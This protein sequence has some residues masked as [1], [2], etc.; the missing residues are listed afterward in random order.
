MIA[1][2]ENFLV[3]LRPLRYTTLALSLLAALA[4]AL[5]SGLGVFVATNGI[6]YDR[7][8]GI[9]LGW[10]R[11]DAKVLMVAGAVDDAARGDETWLALLRQ[12][13]AQGARQ[14]VF[15]FVPRRASELFFE[16]ARRYGNVF[17]GRGLVAD[18]ASR[19][20]VGVEPLPA[21]AA[22]LPSG[23]VTLPPSEHGVYRDGRWT[24]RVG[25]RAVATLVGAVAGGGAELGTEDGFRIDFSGGEAGLPRL[26]LKQA[27]EGGLIPELV[28]G[29]TVL[30]GVDGPELRTLFTPLAERGVLLSPLQ[31]QAH[32]LDTALGG[33]EIAMPGLP[34]VVLLVL[35][36]TFVSLIGFQWL[37]VRVSGAVTLALL[38]VYGAVAWLALHTFHFWAPLSEAWL[39]QGVAYAA[40]VRH[41]HDAVM[42]VLRKIA[43]ESAARLRQR[44][45]P[46]TFFG[47]KAH[48]SQV[49]N[50]VNQTLS[51]ERSIFLERVESDHRVRE[52]VALNCGI[53]DIAEKRRDYERTPYSTAIAENRMLAVKDYMRGG[54]DGETQYLVPLLFAGDVRGFWV[55]GVR[56]EHLHI[57]TESE[58]MI[59]NMSAQI[60]EM[61]YHRQQWQRE[62]ELDANPVARYL[63]LEGGE[64]IAGEAR[65]AVSALEKRMSTLED[66]L[67]GSSSATILYDLFGQVFFANQRMALLLR[68]ANLAPYDMTAADLISS[69]GNFSL[70][71]ARKILRGVILDRRGVTLPASIGSLP[72]QSI[73]L[74]VM[75]LSPRQSGADA[76]AGKTLPF[77]LMGILCELVDVTSIRQ[78][79]QL[80]ETL[81]ERVGFQLRNDLESVVAAAS[82]LSEEGLDP[83]SRKRVLEILRLKTEGMGA[84]LDESQTLLDRGLEDGSLLEC[85][86]VDGKTPL[87]SA[88][89]SLEAEFAA[90]RVSVEIHLP[91]LTSL[92]FAAS[93]ELRQMLRGILQV[94]LRDTSEDGRVEIGLEERERCLHYRFSNTGFGMPDARFQEFLV[95]MP[96]GQGAMA[97]LR[98]AAEL[99]ERWGGSLTGSSEVGEGIRLE[100]ILRAFM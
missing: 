50:M 81:M 90:R 98:E 7:I 86:P 25:M 53:E 62:R 56:G 47:S 82:L 8:L 70:E 54:S 83:D 94:L 91:E 24:E 34:T 67:D 44:L 20:G 22:S 51:L 41:R 19:D 89:S 77:E 84:V 42:A 35:A 33:R 73:A 92:V 27:L 30:V 79:Y 76:E 10:D 43:L 60:A 61:L 55:F 32:M 72:N 26:D 21:Q 46:T 14:V 6:L 28:R 88:L 66:L 71:Q 87:Q 23:V 16:E 38:V 49:V 13:E 9:P 65:D 63:S 100:L 12:A 11:Q 59:R 40:Y 68:E 78:E 85:Y 75:P 29:R 3:R 74:H 80:K 52:V 58:T 64:Q 37:D 15:S 45:F 97:P 17:L 96:D 1:S 18:S 39:A 31:L 5:A 95:S 57:L 2:P 48:W 4:I 93:A 99:A 36:V 69:L